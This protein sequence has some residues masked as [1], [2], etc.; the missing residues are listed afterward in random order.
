MLRRNPFLIALVGLVLASPL[1]AQKPA[2]P[3]PPAG[4]SSEPGFLDLDE[5]GLA[6]P[7]ESKLKVSL[8][9]P[10]LRIL[11]EATKGDEHGFSDLVSKLKAIRANIWQVGP[12]R[13]EAL[14]KGMTDLARRLDRQGW[15]TAVELRTGTGELSLILLRTGADQKILGLAVF[16]VDPSGEAG[17]INIVGN[18]TPEEIGRLGRSL[19]LDPLK[20]FEGAG[21][22]GT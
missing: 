15:E 2:P 14:R 22:P 4:V 18:V 11:A 9:S 17:A 10:V 16:F 5:L 12:D 13:A 6:V 19:D 20:R 1:F 21:K 7:A 8:Y 3:P